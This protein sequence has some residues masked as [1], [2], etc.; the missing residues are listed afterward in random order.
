MS[1]SVFKNA[2]VADARH[3]RRRPWE[4]RATL[5]V[6][7]QYAWQV[8]TSDLSLSGMSVF[9]DV[10]L[11]I[12]TRCDISAT[13][14]LDDKIVTMRVTAENTSCILVNSK[15]FRLGLRIVAADGASR[16]LIKTLMAL[17]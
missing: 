16:E 2:A 12:G 11:P 15:G 4:R 6:G 10:A 5:S 14:P 7:A 1:H 3:E 9:C 8:K 13:F 17:G